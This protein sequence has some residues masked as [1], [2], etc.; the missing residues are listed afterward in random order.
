[1]SLFGRGVM[2]I[3]TLGRSFVTGLSRAIGHIKKQLFIYETLSQ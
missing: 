3:D 1:M 2:V